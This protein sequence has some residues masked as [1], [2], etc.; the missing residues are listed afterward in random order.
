MTEACTFHRGEYNCIRCP[1]VTLYS[2]AAE[3]SVG[4]QFYQESCL[5]GAKC[6]TRIRLEKELKEQTAKE[7]VR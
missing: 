4:N 3:G 7:L 5:G 2:K 6:T 1:E